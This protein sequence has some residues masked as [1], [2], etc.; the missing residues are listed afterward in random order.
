MELMISDGSAID[1]AC[2]DRRASLPACYGEVNKLAA[3]GQHICG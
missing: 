3:S 2:F 1:W